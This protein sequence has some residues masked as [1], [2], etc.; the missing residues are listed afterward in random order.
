MPALGWGPEGHALVA[1]IAEAQLTPAAHAKVIAILGPN[2]SMASMA[3]WADTIRRVRQETGP[4]HY[5][6]IPNGKWHIDKARD[7]PKGACLVQK[8]E[9]FEVMLRDPNTPPEQRREALMFVIHLV[10]DMHQPLHDS[11]NN[12][13]GGNDVHVTYDGRNTNLH[14][15]WD[16]GLL[17]KMGKEDDLF[18]AY[19]QESE[20][21]A[22]KW[23]KGS[24]ESWSEQSH[25]VSVKVA[26]GLLP[27]ADTDAPVTITPAYEAQADP[28]IREQIE[29]GG[30]RLARVLNEVL[31]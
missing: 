10:G 21:N 19:L 4:W 15:L 7:C 13:K 26:Y 23:G 9:D 12:D 20:R 27:K 29:K 1:R 16:S 11:N 18:P 5:I 8:V 22:K 30:A 28:V 6:D 2:V 24:V 3:S 14:S 17:G 25:K 31:K